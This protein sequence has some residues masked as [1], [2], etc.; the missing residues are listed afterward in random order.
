MAAA[1][2][3]ALQRERVV[4][5][6]VVA[7]RAADVGVVVGVGVAADAHVVGAGRRRGPVQ[8]R[9]VVDRPVD[10]GLLDARSVEDPQVCVQA[11]VVAER[12]RQQVAAGQIH[13]H[14]VHVGR[15]EGA[16]ADGAV[17]LDPLVSAQVRVQRR[18]QR[19]ADVG[20]WRD[21]GLRLARSGA[22]AQHA[23]AAGGRHRD[24]ARTD[25]AG[26]RQRQQLL[27]DAV[28][29]VHD[30]AHT[31]VAHPAPVNRHTQ[32]VGRQPRAL[33]HEGVAAGHRA[34]H[35]AQ[36]G[37]DLQVDARTAAQHR[38]RAA[39][40][41][42]RHHH[43]ERAAVATGRA[44]ARERAELAAV[45]DALELHQRGVGQALAL[46]HDGLA[47][48]RRGLRRVG[49]RA[50]AGA[51]LDRVEHAGGLAG[52]ADTGEFGVAAL[53]G[54]ADRP[55]QRQRCHHVEAVVAH[56]GDI[57]RRQVGRVVHQRHA[58]DRDRGGALHE[59]RAAQVEL[60]VAAGL[61]RV[62]TAQCGHDLQL[63]AR[64]GAEGLRAV[65]IGVVGQ[66]L[67]QLAHA[68]HAHVDQV[69]PGRGVVAVPAVER[70]QIKAQRVGLARSQSAQAQ[71]LAGVVE[72]PAEAAEHRH[73]VAVDA[74][75]APGRAGR[76]RLEVVGE[77][78]RRAVLDDH[79]VQAPA[80]VADVLQP[81]VAEGNGRGA[82][83][84]R[85]AQRDVA[86]HRIGVAVKAQVDRALVDH[87]HIARG[88][89][90]GHQHLQPR[91]ASVDDQ[92]RLRHHPGVARV[93]ADVEQH[94]RA[95]AKVRAVQLD[96]LAHV[97]RRQRSVG[98]HT[99][100]GRGQHLA[101]RGGGHRRRVGLGVELVDLALC[102]GDPEGARRVERQP[103]DL[104][105]VDALQ[106]GV[107]APQLGQQPRAVD[108]VLHQLRP[109]VGRAQPQVPGGRV[110][111]QPR[112]RLDVE[113]RGDRRH[114]RTR[115]R[116]QLN[117]PVARPVVLRQ[118]DVA[119]GRV[120]RR[121][122]Q[123]V[124]AVQ[125]Q[126]G[127]HQARGRVDRQH[128]VVA[129]VA[130]E[131][132][133]A[134][135]RHAR[136]AQAHRR[137]HHLQA[138]V[139]ER[140]RRAEAVVHRDRLQH[141]PGARRDLQ[142]VPRVG[143]VAHP[144][145]ARCV[146][147]HV[148][149]AGARHVGA[150]AVERKRRARA[151]GGGDGHPAQPVRGQC[152][153][154][155]VRRPVLLDAVVVHVDVV[156]RVD[157]GVDRAG[158]G[159]AVGR[160]TLHIARAEQH[161]AV[162]HV[163]AADRGHNLQ[164][165]L[166]RRAEQLQRIRPIDIDRQHQRGARAVNGC[167]RGREPR[168]LQRPVD[169]GPAQQDVA[170][171]VEPRARQRDGLPGVGRAL[172]RVSR[173]A[174]ERS[175]RHRTQAG[176]VVRAC[177]A[178]S[179][180]VDRPKHP[181]AQRHRHPH[182]AVAHVLTQRR[183]VAVEHVRAGVDPRIEHRGRPKLVLA[184]VALHEARAGYEH[185]RARPV[186]RDRLHLHVQHRGDDL[187]R[188]GAVGEVGDD[189]ADL[190]VDD[191][192]AGDRV[193]RHVEVGDATR[194][195]GTEHVD[196]RG[197][198]GTVAV[199]HADARLGRAGV[200]G[201][202]NADLLTC[203]RRWRGGRLSDAGVGMHIARRADREVPDDVRRQQVADAVGDVVLDDAQLVVASRQETGRDDRQP[204]AEGARA[205]REVGGEVVGR[206]EDAVR[207]R[208]HQRN[209]GGREQ[210]GVDGFTEHHVKRTHQEHA[211]TFGH[212]GRDHAGREGVGHHVQ[213]NC[214]GQR[215]VAAGIGGPHLHRDLVAT[216]GDRGNRG[217]E[218]ER[219]GHV[220]G[221]DLAVDQQFDIAHLHVVGHGGH[222][223]QRGAFLHLGAGGGRVNV[224]RLDRHAHGRCHALGV[225][226][227]VVDDLQAAA[228][229]GHVGQ[230]VGN[231]HVGRI[232]GQ[233]KAR[234][235]GAGI[236]R[237]A[238]VDDV[239][240]ADAAE[241]EAPHQDAQ[242]RAGERDGSADLAVVVHSGQ[243]SKDVQVADA[244]RHVTAGAASA[245]A[246][247]GHPAAHEELAA[248]AGQRH[249]ATRNDLVATERKRAQHM[250]VVHREEAGTV[251]RQVDQCRAA[252]GAD[253]EA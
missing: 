116:A 29:A 89:Q 140:I 87:A 88:G 196:D 93:V 32:V 234:D 14:Q 46:Q 49:G 39:A 4:T 45:V 225:V 206:A 79:V 198:D 92:R 187:Q 237:V 110:D 80:L 22:A 71:P 136:P 51:G 130:V 252:D 157:S 90:V 5:G 104:V 181:V 217:E 247:V 111:R 172:A 232:G 12:D 9:A 243:H 135:R 170:A 82:G 31:E 204:L 129:R 30:S 105:L 167:R 64:T 123:V 115:G 227:G 28:G 73:R 74:R 15:S 1:G 58:T 112:P 77:H 248:A 34:A 210:R 224:H 131:H 177:A 151:T 229:V 132:Q 238:G 158:P 43:G 191:P 145:V 213:H 126:A 214:V 188:E 228:A 186:T 152:R 201:H 125:H 23:A 53:G 66:R 109:A 48:H 169:V 239:Q 21:V 7:A 160:R 220:V 70:E 60:R 173:R 235:E 27:I 242:T 245:S 17:D 37:H 55:V 8:H 38:D 250:A 253:I 102:R 178:C 6:V 146:H 103:R 212:V 162:L 10:A 244:G 91:A 215:G 100:V 230:A 175:A 208:A 68:V 155:E 72:A 2:A 205:E 25:A 165:R 209:T 50:R 246:Q 19:V 42:C 94:P 127:D 107:H 65:H 122:R 41:Q 249:V 231:G 63:D 141:L 137:T 142:Q 241:V 182:V 134:A 56:A 164:Q 95:G 85:E 108:A 221:N 120:E 67:V 59:A 222:D 190:A 133:Q 176:A 86:V 189:L 119:V 83:A 180:D 153:A 183:V 121:P 18:S 194:G 78:R 81:A 166:A 197:A 218:L 69:R 143:L 163:D 207:T 36:R 161:R 75:V 202:R 226:A 33:E 171:D 16:V 3:V 233:V 61:A 44:G 184:V 216:G 211:G 57:E 144:E 40:R 101:E 76:A 128:P 159:K 13:P 200:E 185:R 26:H 174:A 118:V 223:S 147:R 192:I 149:Q 199:D 84:G 98:R 113:R 139:V 20:R 47:R 114:L 168:H 195:I 52:T 251:Q 179:L 96:D 62:G 156:V 219:E 203:I 97:G 106:R 193:H 148:A 54:D 11:R 99:A 24:D 154:V 150:H 236:G 138:Q 124:V 117:D 35:R 240:R